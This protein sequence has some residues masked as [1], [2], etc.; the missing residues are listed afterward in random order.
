MDGVLETKLISAVASTIT[1]HGIGGAGSCSDTCKSEEPAR[2]GIEGYYPLFALAYG[3][4]FSRT[5]FVRDRSLLCISVD[6]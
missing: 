1:R 5:G 3:K 4:V 2:Y 6:K